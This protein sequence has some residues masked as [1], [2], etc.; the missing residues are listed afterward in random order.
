MMRSTLALLREYKEL[1]TLEDYKRWAADTLPFRRS[2]GGITGDGRGEARTPRNCGCKQ[3]EDCDGFCRH[4]APPQQQQAAPDGRG[5]DAQIIKE[6]EIAMHAIVGALAAGYS[7]QEHPGG[8]HW[9]AA[10]H[11]A[12]TRIASLEKQL[13]AAPAWEMPDAPELFKFINSQPILQSLLY[14]INLLPEVIKDAEHFGYMVAV[15]NHFEMALKK[16]APG[17]V[18]DGF[19]MAPVVPTD[20]M[21][22][23][24]VDVDSF[25]LGDISPIG[26]RCSPQRL[27]ERCYAAMLSAAPKV[28]TQDGWLPIET[29]PKEPGKLLL[30]YVRNAR[31]GEDDDGRYRETDTS[32]VDFIEWC[33]GGEHGDGYFMATAGPHGDHGDWITHWMPLPPAPKAQEPVAMNINQGIQNASGEF[34]PAPKAIK[35]SAASVEAMDDTADYA[36]KKDK[37]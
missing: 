5:T 12:G 2:D 29:A 34:M 7:G 13:Q 33:E 20:A 11:D 25:K 36:E 37:K 26:F 27:F 35:L 24:A 19:V 8:D 28:A 4:G 1:V 31:I 3:F 22:N 23:A 21:L 14:D 10:A 32:T 6:R 30:G 17:D 9:L 18:Q 15:C 16:A